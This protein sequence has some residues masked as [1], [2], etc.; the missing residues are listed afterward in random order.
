MIDFWP[1]T[2][3]FQAMRNTREVGDRWATSFL[4]PRRAAAAIS[5]FW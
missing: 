4:N 1:G 5:R 3:V 2:D